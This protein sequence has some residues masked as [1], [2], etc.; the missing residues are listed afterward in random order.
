M[1]RDP[2]RSKKGNKIERATKREQEVISESKID[3]Q[4]RQLNNHPLLAIIE[5]QLT[6]FIS[7]E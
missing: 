7:H 6:T 5:I 4:V 3:E 2:Y 1:K